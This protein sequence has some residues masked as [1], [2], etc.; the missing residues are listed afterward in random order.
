MVPGT[1]IELYQLE[2]IGTT[3]S[4]IQQ[5]VYHEI[6]HRGQGRRQVAQSEG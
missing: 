6:K 4:V 5:E 2:D 3:I 1:K